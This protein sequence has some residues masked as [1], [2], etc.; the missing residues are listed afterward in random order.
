[1]E[2]DEDDSFEMDDNEDNEETHQVKTKTLVNLKVKSEMLS[3]LAKS[4]M[5]NW[6]RDVLDLVNIDVS[7]YH[8]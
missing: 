2:K 4:G 5:K 8:F 1:M 6:E 7:K 3:I